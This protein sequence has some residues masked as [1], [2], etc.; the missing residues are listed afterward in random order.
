MPVRVYNVKFEKETYFFV[1]FFYA[2]ESWTLLLDHVWTEN[3]V[4]LHPALDTLYCP[5]ILLESYRIFLKMRVVFDPR[6]VHAEFVMGRM[7]AEIFLWALL[8]YR[9]YVKRQIHKG[10]FYNLPHWDPS[11]EIFVSK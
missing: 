11:A 5:V 9:L 3:I 6:V 8:N 4:N 1:N 2:N 7:A 10:V